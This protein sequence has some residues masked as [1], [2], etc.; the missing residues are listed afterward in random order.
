MRDSSY[1]RS[2]PDDKNERSLPDAADNPDEGENLC[3]ACVHFRPGTCSNVACI[4]TS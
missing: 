2:G 1:R 3:D 4:D